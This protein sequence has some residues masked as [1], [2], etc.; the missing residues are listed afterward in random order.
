MI[1]PE[2][3]IKKSLAHIL[4]KWKDAEFDDNYIIEQFRSIR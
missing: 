3:I 4:K 1:R 2:H